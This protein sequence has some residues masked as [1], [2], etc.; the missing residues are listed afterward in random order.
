M[1]L[2]SPSCSSTFLGYT[3]LL[4]SASACAQS[5][6]TT[7]TVPSHA[8][9]FAPS[10]ISKP[11]ASGFW[12]LGNDLVH[13][14][15]DG[16]LDFSVD[17]VANQPQSGLTTTLGDGS[18]L[19][20]GP[21]HASHTT[22]IYDYCSVSAFSAT[23]LPR[24]TYVR[25]SFNNFFSPH[26]YCQ[27]LSVDAR[28]QIWLETSDFA[29][30]RLAGDGAVI[31]DGPALPAGAGYFADV[32]ANPVAAG[33]FVVTGNSPASV[34]GV[35]ENTN[36]LWTWADPVATDSLQRIVVGRDGN[37]YVA[38]RSSPASS[39][40]GMGGLV[41]GSLT[42]DG[43][44]RFLQTHTDV[45]LSDL[46]VMT[47]AA[48]GALYLL[49]YLPNPDGTVKL[50]LQ[51]I[52]NDGAEQWNR[53]LFDAVDPAQACGNSLLDCVLTVS[54]QDDVLT[55]GLQSL[56]SA[57][58]LF[59]FDSSGNPLLM[60]PLQNAV[61]RSLASLANGDA[62][63]AIS[64]SGQP[65]VFV[66][67]NRSG[68][69]QTPPVTHG[70]INIP[71]SFSAIAADGSTYLAGELATAF[72]L[73]KVSEDGQ[74]V[75]HH[76]FDTPRANFISVGGDR[77]CVLD[78]N[79]SLLTCFA[80]DSG[81]KIW[82]TTRPIYPFRVLDDGNVMANTASFANPVQ[83]EFDRAG[84]VVHQTALS[85]ADS[86]P[87]SIAANGTILFFSG[88]YSHLLAYDRHG[89]FIYDRMLP[90]ELT[91]SNPPPDLLVFS[92]G[93]VLVTQR[94]DFSLANPA[95]HT[96]VGLISPSG[97]VRWVQTLAPRTFTSSAL[98]GADGILYLGLATTD[99]SDF[100]IIAQ[101]IEAI[102]VGSGSVLWQ[103]S[104]VT[105]SLARLLI[106]QDPATGRLLLAGGG[107]NSKIG[108][109]TIDQTTGA[110]LNSRYMP[111]PQCDNL[112]F[113]AD[114]TL[115]SA[116]E[117]QHVSS[118]RN[119]TA[120][121]PAIRVDQPGI[122]GA[123][124]ASYESG[125]GFW[126][127]YFASVNAVFMPWFTYAP[128][129]VNDPS[130]LA[131]YTLQGPLAA[132]ATSS[133]L[134]ITVTAPG[135]FNTGSVGVH[136]VGTAH[137]SFTD[138]HSAA[139]LYQFD[140]TVN[141]GAG[142]LISLTRLTPS[143][144]DCSL[145][146]GSITPAQIPNVPAKGFDARQSGSWYDPD[147]SGQ[148]LEITVLPPA[149]GFGGA[150]FA[151]WF[152]FDP[153]NNSND[154]QHQHWFTLQGDLSTASDGKVQLAVLQ[155]VGGSLDNAPSSNILKV[156]DAT[157][158]MQGCDKAVFQF[159]FS[160]DAAAHAFKGLAG[161]SQLSKLGGCTAQ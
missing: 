2:R 77:V 9:D 69:V 108:L 20:A 41:V 96:Y 75:W 89:A 81:A 148:G 94:P 112:A 149:T 111:C 25:G 19:F 53:V 16:T 98:I 51:R 27:A 106:L 68:V 128:E 118:L 1:L 58:Q 63:L 144:A 11:D 17:N 80:T 74:Q 93:S 88:N 28:Q 4:L 107:N 153:A 76:D 91:R 100:N 59:R 139:L 42:P 10:A 72:S 143:T 116:Y 23:G 14:H 54:P 32:A 103:N 123:W 131:W 134:A 57:P 79:A 122:D 160:Q 3:L 159:Q 125:Q 15:A 12:A 65:S 142:G 102:S 24:W 6:D 132:G 140:A 55:L 36:I 47:P 22:F 104:E 90:A 66:Q 124:F 49:D 157:L 39:A 141:N 61:A 155:S 50:A 147:T 60:L 31:G 114:G 95:A 121:A 119:A 67:V 87:P 84:N 151:G 73:T 45:Q 97:E 126:I 150:V 99:D 145:A 35:D 110:E 70:I 115:V 135:S 5:W 56:A 154:D 40:P 43:T 83:I 86:N 8:A 34:L 46:L 71:T 62:L 137:L 29:I 113:A 109:V 120:V 48:G 136:Q 133:D 82:S 101:T 37:V 44:L 130:G 158:T 127:D 30:T 117:S 38:G 13:Y 7:Y 26:G 33:A 78:A 152:T 18:V 64:T 92:D 85:P 161:T 156:G 21:A 52:G 129:P 138:C 105:P 146:D